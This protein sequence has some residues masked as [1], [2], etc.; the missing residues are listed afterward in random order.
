MI[1]S[2]GAGEP[3]VPANMYAESDFEIQSSVY[4]WT[5]KTL[6][7][8]ER[9][10]RVRIRL[11]GDPSL[12]ESGEIF[13]FNHFARFETFIPQYLIYRQTGAYC[14]SVA[15]GEFFRGSEALSR[16]LRSLGAVPNDWDGLLPF[17]AAEVLRGRKVVVF[18]E[19]GM[20][21]DRR[22]IDEAGRYRVYSRTARERRKHHTGAAVV[23]L[24][25]EGFKAAVRAAWKQGDRDRV[26][27]WAE[28]LGLDA[29]EV[30]VGRAGRPTRI[31]PGNITFY[32]IRIQENFLQKGA[33]FFYKGLT[34][35]MSEELLIEGNL[36]LKDSDMDIRLADPLDVWEFLPWWDRRLV[37]GVARSTDGP[38][39]LIA[40]GPA[41]LWVRAWRR[42]ARRQAMRLRDAY[43][44]SMYAA[45]TVNLSHLVS[46][47]IFGFLE[48]GLTEVPA[49]RLHRAVYLAVKRA[50]ER[51]RLHLHPSVVEPARYRGLLEDRCPGLE[52]LVDT[53]RRAGL[54][55][56]GEDGYR[57]SEKL[58]QE[59]G[60]DEIRVENPLAV[61]A[62]EVAPLAGVR[63]AVERA[64]EEEERL[65]GA[66]WARLRFDDELR[67]QEL[68]L[69]SIDRSQDPER[70]EPP[71][72]PSEPFLL[73]PERPKGLAVV[74]V[75]GFSASPAEMRPFGER[76]ASEAYPVVGVRLAGHG[77]SPLA[78]ERTT[79][80]DWLESARRG[81]SIAALL[82]DRVAVVGFSAGG[83]LALCL[84]A[85][86]PAG[87]AG[88]AAVAAPVRV[89]D[90]GM[91]LVPL[92]HGANVLMGTLGGKGMLRFHRTE[93]EHPDINYRH[94]PLE[95]L[96]QLGQLIGA[97]Q[98]RL[99]RVRCPVLLVQG[100]EDPTVDP[101]SAEILYKGLPGKDK[102]LVLIPS[103]RH[104]I[105]LEDVGGTRD[106]ILRFLE[107]L[108][109]G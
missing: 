4:E 79:W 84:A 77:T 68:E 49:A 105:L 16:Y 107:D 69:R 76:L 83:C 24:A 100:S 61:Y 39:G 59:H 96:Y 22:V 81:F 35:R 101:E 15:G 64:L 51:P 55:E 50:Q 85:E 73:V 29:P 13:L 52:Q 9:V 23:G 37:V 108:R 26:A 86:E 91:R 27:R 5:A 78:M 67:D 18:P 70:E 20:V 63:K 7:L 1:A 45:V 82:A 33:E 44:V 14:R 36:L 88:V 43:M 98:E 97:T 54:V 40:N 71:K 102:A 10:L 48:Q 53:A 3:P 74:L 80:E 89:R 25:V 99:E 57:F 103:D 28:K 90:R 19:G 12:L 58:C 31:V 30:L 62:N 34:P 87:L 93:P 92:V 8:L 41:G 42:R 32:P 66:E 65:P 95:G 2:F 75:H 72:K 60:I 56:R 47:V 21:K 94:V 46:R 104:G 38:G 17:L 11:H 6:A 109:G 106:R